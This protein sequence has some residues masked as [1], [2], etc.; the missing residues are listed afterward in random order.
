MTGYIYCITN[1]INQKQYIGQTRFSLQE[2]WRDHCKNAIDDT[3]SNRPLYR[4]MRKYGI[5]NFTIT[6]LEEVPIE[7]LD[8]AE[9]RWIQ[10]LNTYHNGY[11]ATLGGE[12]KQKYNQEIYQ[13]FL[14]LYQQGYNAQQIAEQYKC[15]VDTV[16]KVL[17]CAGF[18]T[19]QNARTQMSHPVTQYTLEMC[20]IQTYNSCA[21]AAK[22]L[23]QSGVQASIHTIVT[24]IG[25]VVRGQRAS[26]Y[27]FK[28]Q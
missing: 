2:R 12:G 5:D 1:S 14:T 13:Q 4:A 28:W 19:L 7:E 20:P 23:K 22:M 21:A 25:R 11:N 24:N 10:N 17:I 18:D 26:C 3:K 9:Q 6:L 16:S 8:Q 15:A 27:G